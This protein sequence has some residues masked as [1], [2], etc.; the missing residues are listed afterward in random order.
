VLR[1]EYSR[2]TDVTKSFKIQAINC[3]TNKVIIKYAVPG[4]ARFITW[5][6]A[7]GYAMRSGRDM[8]VFII[9]RN[10]SQEKT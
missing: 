10:K 9:W 1:D 2:K 4:T 5:Y 6:K 8:A 7:S 3:F